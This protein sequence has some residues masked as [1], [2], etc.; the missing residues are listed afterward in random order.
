MQLWQTQD[1]LFT[2]KYTNLNAKHFVKFQDPV[3]IFPYQVTILTAWNTTV[4]EYE[5][6]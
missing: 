2:S 3:R 5:H 1:T 6:K 4:H